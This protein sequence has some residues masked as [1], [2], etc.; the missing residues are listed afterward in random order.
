MS[1]HF[2]PKRSTHTSASSRKSPSFSVTFAHLRL[3][4]GF[5]IV[6]VPPYL[7]M[8]RQA[9]HLPHSFARHPGHRPHRWR[10]CR[11]SKHA[12]YTQRKGRAA[13]ERTAYREP[14]FEAICL[15][16]SVLVVTW[17]TRGV[18]VAC[19]Q[20]EYK[21]V[22][23]KKTSVKA[24]ISHEKERANN[25]MSVHNISFSPRSRAQVQQIAEQCALP[26][27]CSSAGQLGFL[28]PVDRHGIGERTSQ[29]QRE[30]SSRASLPNQSAQQRQRTPIVRRWKSTLTTTKDNTTAQLDLQRT[31][32]ASAGCHN[33]CSSS[34]SAHWSKS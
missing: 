17:A 28:P 1:A 25:S 8:L 29:Q 9:G 20:E 24:E 7:R 3:S 26:S 11:D 18:T 19:T 22:H 12:Q 15:L 16:N 21:C 6:P 31:S 30:P 32:I 10:L 23:S 27:H 13:G 4:H 2:M 14:T 5:F 33:S 34:G